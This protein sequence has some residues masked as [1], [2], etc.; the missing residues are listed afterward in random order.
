MRVP[1]GFTDTYRIMLG[2]RPIM[3]CENQRGCIGA[4][5][6]ISMTNNMDKKSD[7]YLGK[8][9]GNSSGSCYHLYD[10]GNQ[11]SKNLDRRE[12]RATFA[13]IE[14]ETNILGINGPRKLNATIAKLDDID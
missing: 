13:K 1:S 6:Y 5:Y 4:N 10:N 7:A 8:L 9:R 2:E 3:F 14:Y 11:P 12:W